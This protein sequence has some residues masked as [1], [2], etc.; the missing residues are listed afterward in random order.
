MLFRSIKRT[1]HSI[2]FKIDSLTRH[3]IN[4]SGTNNKIGTLYWQDKNE[5]NV[6]LYAYGHIPTLSMTLITS[7][8]IN[9]FWDHYSGSLFAGAL[10]ALLAI[11]LGAIAISGIINPLIKQLF[12]AQEHL[13][14]RILARTNELEEANHQLIE[15]ST[16]RHTAEMHLRHSIQLMENIFDNTTNAV[17]V[18]GTDQNTTQ[19]NARA[20]EITG[21]SIE[22]IIHKPFINALSGMNNEPLQ[23]N[24]DLVLIEGATLHSISVMINVGE[25]IKHITVGMSPL[26]ENNTVIGAVC[27]AQDVTVQKLAEIGLIKTKEKAIAASKSK[28]EFLANMSHEIRTPMNG[29]LGMLSLL[30]D[31]KLNQEQ[32]EYAETAF[33]SGELLM[34]ILNDIL[35]FS[36]IEAGKLQLEKIDFDLKMAIED[37]S[38]LLA[39]RAH[40]KNIEIN[41][42]LPANMPRMV[43]GDPTRLR[44]IIINLLG[45]AIKFTSDGE[46]ITRVITL[47]EC[48]K[49]YYLRIEVTDTGVGINNQAQQAIFDSF[50]QEDGS[51]TRK[52]GG[53]GLGLSICRQLVGLMQ[54]EI[55]VESELGKGSTFWFEIS[56]DKSDKLFSEKESI[57]D[58]SNI[59]VLIVDDNQTNRTIYTKL[60]KS[61]NI[62]SSTSESGQDAITTLEAAQ[63]NNKPFDLVL[64]DFMMPG[65]DG[66]NVS[67]YIREHKTLSDTNIIILTSMNDDDSR[68]RIQQL[69]VE[70]VLTKPVR[71]STL[72]DTIA[73]QLGGTKIIETKSQTH[74]QK[75]ITVKPEINT[76]IKILLAEDNAVNQKVTIGILKKLGYTADIAEDGTQA[77]EKCMHDQYDLIF[78]DCHMPNTDGYSATRSIRKS[79]KNT[80][81]PIVAMTAN[82]MQHDRDK[83]IQ[84]GMNDYISKPIRPETVST[85]LQTWL[86]AD[87]IS[88]LV[89]KG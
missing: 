4:I 20:T 15:E 39:Q 19:V 49:S 59:K 6:R 7:I 26:F 63:Q 76:G 42:D 30:C 48:E 73:N 44:Q 77:I 14:E 62:S 46:V 1:I 37:I 68:Q 2:T 31:T 80:T 87:P 53:T 45:N 38:S 74:E 66:L 67:K 43:I 5:P 85:A 60:L 82:A 24:I 8:S 65:M 61:W 81:T 21:L 86:L 54:G 36:K 23:K 75:N 22:D 28:S 13:E 27:T 83:C 47:D 32:R 52:F 18:I 57:A 84:A 29:V 25:I 58:L 89:N 10:L 40:S 70:Y 79:G 71:S 33:G 56:L 16:D 69:G 78:M 35:D 55:G 72:F 51:T 34:N 41:Y 12:N 9:E 64:L 50:S 17:F 88:P 11:V 3:I